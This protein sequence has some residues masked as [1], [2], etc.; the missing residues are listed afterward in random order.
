VPPD[1][2][3]RPILIFGVSQRSGTNLL[4]GLLSLH[5]MCG[6]PSDPVREAH[7]LHAA[8]SLLEYADRTASRWPARWGDVA[9]ARRDLVSSLGG[10]LLHFLSARSDAPRVVA[11]TPEGTHLALAGELLGGSDI[12]LLVRDGRAVTESLVKGFRYSYGRAARRWRAGARSFLAVMARA[13]VLERSRDVRIRLVRYEDLV[14]HRDDAIASILRHC[15]LDADDFD[16]DAARRFPVAGSSFL[17]DPLSGHMSWQP[18]E[19]PE[20]FDPIN[21]HANWGRGEYARFIYV[22]GLEQRALGYEV[23]PLRLS[24]TR[25]LRQYLLDAG[26][27]LAVVRDQVQRRLDWYT[28]N[29][30][31]R[32]KQ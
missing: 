25:R 17:R 5:P 26:T 9:G 15:R 30:V 18:Q 16:W 2:S 21:R 3:S 19:A 28:S 8:P 31:N 14:Q 32:S 13:E 4:A 6:P 29:R 22:A 7:L 24:P 1:V 23:G 12:L 20:N 10:G 27:P 11:K